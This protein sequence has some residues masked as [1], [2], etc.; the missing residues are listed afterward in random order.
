[1]TAA[2][3]ARDPQWYRDAIIYQLHVKTFCDSNGDGI[4][5]FA[6]LTS[7]LD[8]LQQLGITCIWLLPFYASPLRDDGYD[9]SHYERVLPAYGTLHDFRVFLAEA[10]SRGLKVITELVIN[11]TSD[12]HPWFQAARHAPAGS[13][14]RD[15]YVWS[16]SAD[17]YADARV[18]FSD[19]ESSNWSW[20]PV[21][22]AFYWHR[23]FHHQPDLNFDN[24]AVRRAALRVMRFWLDAGVDGLRLDA[25]AHL[26]EREGTTCE[27]LPETHEFL[28]QIRREMDERYD[29]RVLLAEANGDAVRQYFGTGDECHMAFDFGLMSCL[30]VA[31]TRG[32]ATPITEALLRECV[33]DGCQWATFLRNHDEF[34]LSSLPAHDQDWLLDVCAPDPRM[35]LHGGIR[36]RLAPLLRHRNRIELAFALLLALPGSPIVYYGDEIGMGDDIRLPDR[37]GIRTPM[38]WSDDVHGGFSDSRAVRLVTPVI[39]DSVYGYRTVNVAAELRDPES[40]LSRVRRLLAVRRRHRAFGRGSIQLLPTGNPAVLALVRRFEDEAIVVAANLSGSSV[41]IALDLPDVFVGSTLRE[42]V[43]DVAFPP[44]GPQPYRLSLAPYASYWLHC[45]G[46]GAPAPRIAQV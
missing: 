25:V 28:R 11:H 14:K 10:H 20:D 21:A 15:F 39:D 30:F 45:V 38:Q 43:D 1:M 23:F 12:R 6:G 33:P 41:S 7:K 37:D 5:D 2:G 42:L 16:E 18:I 8:Y 17:R 32:E 36:R 19:A 27:N 4:G 46:A 22:R 29:G 34:G 13:R 35:R 3:A 9:I 26:F 31:V 44:A 40:L 24:P